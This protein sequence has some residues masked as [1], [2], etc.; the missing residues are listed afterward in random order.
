MQEVARLQ[1][2]TPSEDLTNRAKETAKRQYETAV[3]QNGFWLARLQSA[4]LLGR[5]PL[6]MLSRLQRIESVTP[7]LLHETFKKY[8]PADRSTVVT[9]LPEK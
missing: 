5:D 1:K 4:K 9:L 8:F 2:E 6:L 7:A 3:R